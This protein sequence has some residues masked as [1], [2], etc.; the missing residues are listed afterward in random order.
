MSGAVTKGP[1]AKSNNKEAHK[2]A[3]LDVDH[4]S[5]SRLHA[6]RTSTD[7]RPT[8]LRTPRRAKRIDRLLKTYL[9]SRCANAKVPH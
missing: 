6:A 7:D 5:V 4:I 1:K 3:G 2:A 8:R 9:R